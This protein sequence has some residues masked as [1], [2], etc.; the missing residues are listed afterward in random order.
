MVTQ[1]VP[2]IAVA[3]QHQVVLAIENHIDLLAD[4]M[5]DLLTTLAKSLDYLRGLLA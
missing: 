3:K 4:E 5:L 2:L 1:L